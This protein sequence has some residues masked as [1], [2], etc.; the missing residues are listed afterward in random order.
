MRQ[1]QTSYT[2]NSRKVEFGGPSL[3]GGADNQLYYNLSA[4][5][6]LKRKGRREAAMKPAEN[7]SKNGKI[8]REKL[9][10]REG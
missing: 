1:E 3:V 6:A 8:T 7:A 9:Y 5:S 2:S 10:A 4:L